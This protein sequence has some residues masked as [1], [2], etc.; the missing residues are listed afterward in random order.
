MRPIFQTTIGVLAL[1]LSACETKTPRATT[2]PPPQPAS[3]KAEP[4]PEPAPSEPLSMPQTQ[5]RLPNPQPIDPQAL[6]AP[7]VSVP[8][9]PPQQ[10][11]ARRSS[12]RPAPQPAATPGKPEATETA[13]TPPP[14]E[15]QRALIGPVLSD[16]ERRRLN[17]DIASRLKGVDQMLGRLAALRLSDAEKDSVEKIRSF[18]KLA[19]EAM[20]H[21]E[22]QQA[23]GLA[24]RAVLLAQEVLRG[25]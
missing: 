18:E 5:V 23:S 7:P 1:L 8:A 21:G 3:A 4:Q 17:E 12:K 10:R 9:E 6:A 16:D 19:R 25:R 22:I 20:D 13:D 11:Q 24:D 15:T 2:V 14:T